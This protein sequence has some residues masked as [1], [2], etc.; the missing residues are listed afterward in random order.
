M[1]PTASSSRTSN[2]HEPELSLA[3]RADTSEMW[4]VQ[5][6]C[7]WSGT[8][9]WCPSL[10]ERIEV[11][12]HETAGLHW[13]AVAQNMAWTMHEAVSIAGQQLS[14][15]VLVRAVGNLLEL[16]NSLKEKLKLFLTSYCW[17]FR[18]QDVDDQQSACRGATA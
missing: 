10:Q 4:A 15:S 16:P 9:T 11:H 17:T 2:G 1:H 18:G 8:A 5:Q 6:T 13:L 7:T 14:R 12:H 3:S